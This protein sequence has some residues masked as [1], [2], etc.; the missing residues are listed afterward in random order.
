MIDLSDYVSNIDTNVNKLYNPVAKNV[1]TSSF[2]SN[3]HGN[4]AIYRLGKLVFL[5]GFVYCST[6]LTAGTA[7]YLFSLSYEGIVCAAWLGGLAISYT[8]AYSGNLSASSDGAN[9]MLTPR[10][11]STPANTY[12]VIFGAYISVYST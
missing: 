6:S 4:I 10:Q 3:W 12:Y 9:I 11:G 8:D 7:S 5:Y 1:A 2:L